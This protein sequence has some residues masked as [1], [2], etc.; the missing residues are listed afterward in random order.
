VDDEAEESDGK[1][2]DRQAEAPAHHLVLLKL[3]TQ[4]GAEQVEGA[5]RHVDDA[6]QPEDEGEAAGDDEV[7]AGQGQAGQRHANPVGN[8]AAG[9]EPA[10]EGPVGDPGES[11]EKGGHTQ[12]ARGT[13]ARCGSQ[14]MQPP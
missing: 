9:A 13:A 6:H 5:V 10:P 2:R 12:R 3:V 8:A 14:R 7:E 11:D 1:R 4:V